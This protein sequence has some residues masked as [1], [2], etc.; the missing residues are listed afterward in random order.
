LH[1][2]NTAVRNIKKEKQMSLSDKK[3]LEILTGVGIETA[4]P[5][6]QQAEI[7]NKL[8]RQEIV[9]VRLQEFLL[10]KF[11]PEILGN[12][13]PLEKNALVDRVF[14]RA[15]FKPV[16]WGIGNATAS[17]LPFVKAEC[18]QCR[19]VETIV[20]REPHFVFRT[21]PDGQKQESYK[22]YSLTESL[23]QAREFKF[24]HHCEGGKIEQIPEDVFLV[25]TQRLSAYAHNGDTANYI[26]TD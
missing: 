1:H 25:Y 15:I 19:R 23:M 21:L 13:H 6:A 8:L 2:S 9:G 5:T 18:P 17:G 4:V 11:G 14:P 3:V 10:T 16:V 26:T 7:A 20:V 22:K 24:R 12:L